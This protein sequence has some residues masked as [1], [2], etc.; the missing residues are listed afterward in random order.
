MFV[1][2]DDDRIA[3]A[4]SQCPLSDGG[5][6]ATYEDVT[7][8]QRTEGRIR[9]MAHHDTLTQLPN[10]VLF[11]NSMDEVLGHLSKDGLRLA[12]LYLDLDKFKYVNDT[13]GHPAGD[14][15][16]EAVARRLQA[17]VRDADIVARLGGDEFA[18]LYLS[19]ELPVAATALAQRLID[20]LSAPYQIGHR[21]VDVGVSIGIAIATGAD[22]DGDTLLKNADMA[23]YQAKAK[24]QAN[25]VRL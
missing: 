12:L 9:F 23:L 3:L 6:V 18:I 7:E 17:C 14:V 5:W 2:I 24:G 19:T 10:R 1:T 4:I 25:L 21:Q 16:L 13:L 15:L 8:Q 20:T 11:H 22:M